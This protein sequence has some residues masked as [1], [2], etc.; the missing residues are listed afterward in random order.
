VSRQRS[1]LD[2][3]WT[4]PIHPSQTRLLVLQRYVFQPFVLAGYGGMTSL[5][6]ATQATTT[7]PNT[8]DPITVQSDVSNRT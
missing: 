6:S 8:G 5:V 3:G 1:G 7:D 4:F 2:L